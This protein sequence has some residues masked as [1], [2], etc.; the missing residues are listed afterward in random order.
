[1]VVVINSDPVHLSPV[2]HISRNARGSC[3]KPLQQYLIEGLGIRLPKP[4]Q[5]GSGK[6]ELGIVQ[7]GIY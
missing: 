2:H 5:V 6:E 7:W 3:A 1:M 4:L